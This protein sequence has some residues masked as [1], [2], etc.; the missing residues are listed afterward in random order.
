MNDFV[1]YLAF[2]RQ[3]LNAVAP[4]TAEKDIA[5]GH[6]FTVQQDDKKTTLTVYNGKKGR[7][8]VWGG[9]GGALTEALQAAI[10]GR[11]AAAAAENEF[12]GIW[13]GS[14]E[15]GK[16][17]FFGPLVVAAVVVDDK[18]AAALQQAGVR[19][20][21]QL[22]DKKI[23]ELEAPILQ[24]AVDSCVLELKPSVYNFRYRQ[25]KQ[26]GGN[27][28]QLL[29]CGHIAALTQVLQRQPECRKALI[30]QFMRSDVL[31]RSL[32]QTFP[33]VK[34]RQQPKAESNIAVAAASVLARARFLRRMD[35]LSAQAGMLLP[36][37]G[38]TAAT[39]AAQ[40]LAQQLGKE[41][42]AQYVKLH[43]ANYSK[44]TERK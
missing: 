41:A 8:L 38:G 40:Q 4:V 13:A 5:Y 21:K 24:L 12:S 35:E 25:I 1:E 22:T 18:S 30:D 14:D 20:C 23:M 16:G 11:P 28:N 31:L 7:R 17:D 29:G 10:D 27:L 19:D 42:L 33:E 2:V 32:E 37:G 39:A 26:S 15:S 43:F 6:Q 9:A 34:V 44:I 3:K 36:K